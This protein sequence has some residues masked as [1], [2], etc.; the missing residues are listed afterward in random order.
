MSKSISQRLRRSPRMMQLD[1]QS[2]FTNTAVNVI[3]L[4]LVDVLYIESGN[5]MIFFWLCTFVIR[6][7]SLRVF[8]KLGFVF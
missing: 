2:K 6:V 4:D 1:F 5:I 3:D 8:E 7:F